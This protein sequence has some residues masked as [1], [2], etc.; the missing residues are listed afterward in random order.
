M[1]KKSYAEKQC[2]LNYRTRTKNSLFT[3]LWWWFF[4]ASD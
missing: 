2:N 1:I 4:A 3:P